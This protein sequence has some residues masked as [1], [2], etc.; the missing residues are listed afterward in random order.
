MSI[1]NI[2]S[3]PNDPELA[4]LRPQS[5]NTASIQSRKRK[6][7]EE[8]GRE[9]DW[10]PFT[11]RDPSKPLEKPRVFTPICVLPR[12]K[13]PLAYLDT[14]AYSGRL[15][16]AHVAELERESSESRDG[17]YGPSLVVA[18]SQ[19]AKSLYA[20]E[21]VH[22]Q[23]YAICKLGAWV[24]RLQ[25]EED[26]LHHDPNAFT[27]RPHA[28]AP[29]QG[30]SRP[31]SV[32]RD[33]PSGLGLKQDAPRKAPRLS[34]SALRSGTATPLD[35]PALADAIADTNG[36]NA[37]EAEEHVCTQDGRISKPSTSAAGLKSDVQATN[38]AAP[39]MDNTLAMPQEALAE[40][41]TAEEVLQ[42]LATQ[43]LEAL[44]VSRMSLAYFAKGPLSR[45]RV[46][47]A[48]SS[49]SPIET[50]ALAVFL[51]GLVHTSS[52]TDKKYRDKLPEIV[53]ELVPSATPEKDLTKRKRKA[54][55]VKVDKYGMLPDEADYV[56]R[57]WHADTA[58]SSFET[59]DST[60]RRLVPQLRTRE[61]FLQV[62][63]ILETLALEGS[64]ARP[65][66][67]PSKE[68]S[69]APESQALE[70]IDTQEI[71]K[72]KMKKPQ[73]LT[74]TLETLLDRLCIWHSLDQET[75]AGKKTH[76]K[77]SGSEE[78]ND[79]LKSFCIEVVMPFYMSRIP[80]LAALVNKKL[81]GPSAPT[82]VK[83]NPSAARR[84]GEPA[85]RQAPEKRPR[86]P[87]QRVSTD[88]LNHPARPPPSLT[89]SATDSQALPQ[90]KREDSAISLS[91]IPTKHNRR[92]PPRRESLLNS[93][94]FSK[95]E[96]DLSAMSQAN[97]TKLRKKAEVE[98]K[99]REA[100]TTLKK[101]HRPLAL[102]EIADSADQ[103]HAKATGRAKPG[104]A[105]RARQSVHVSATPKHGR[106]VNA[107][108]N[109]RMQHA[110][111][112]PMPSAGALLVPSSSARLLG[113]TAVP[114]S[115]ME[116]PATGHRQRHVN[117]QE[118]PSRGFAKF[119]PPGLI[120]E[121]GT[122]ESPSM[123][124]RSVNPGAEC[125]TF[126][127]PAVQQTPSKP[128]KTWSLAET[129]VARKV[130]AQSGAPVLATPL[131]PLAQ[132]LGDVERRP[133]R[134]DEEEPKSIYDALGWNDDY[135][136]LA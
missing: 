128:A 7:H 92:P 87:L 84:P 70:A 26:A 54:K 48:T 18:E 10:R 122:L 118:T 127:V 64:A 72:K 69:A 41:R 13:L 66:I 2:A 97:E 31:Q 101:P 80:K 78:N 14:S 38:P 61:T 59:V 32:A 86:K 49:A 120:H 4:R 123:T 113:P 25:L 117:V 11:I 35:S 19:T 76:D 108:A 88:T 51:R 121:P 12:A 36:T 116:V 85:V 106:A 95:R 136:D 60:L 58:S 28:R 65:N 62:I 99:L 33:Q 112:Q 43:Y 91:S 50:D 63:L 47:Y 107:M 57:W 105:Q 30:S 5:I 6:R 135:D 111:V 44:Y 102:K 17:R 22:E 20:V 74:A 82:P 114:S 27:V 98:E 24:D 125:A 15:F 34:I 21:R 73:D 55:K 81:G 89:R 94:S 79:D 134:A 29:S 23:T 3:L 119:L 68:P 75:H 110:S 132:P 67:E 53:K 126:A 39:G 93:I 52:V 37:A 124:R 90:I 42:D 46:A 8:G 104:V 109:G 133:D 130:A 96:V 83:T 56:K 40:Q 9:A 100:I 131:Q 45:A 77:L 71:V 115:T 16:T 103:G 129:P 1:L